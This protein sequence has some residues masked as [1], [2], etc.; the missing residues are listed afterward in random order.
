MIYAAI[1]G[2]AALCAAAESGKS[3]PRSFFALGAVGERGGHSSIRATDGILTLMHAIKAETT[4]DEATATAIP[5][6]RPLLGKHVEIIALQTDGGLTET[7][8]RKFTPAEFF[9]AR[10][11]PP[12]GVGPI[13]LEDMESAIEKG[14]VGAID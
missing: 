14:A 4:V 2:S 6:L 10:L 12:S 1:R 8:T 13:S 11:T 5:A 7:P 3:A 9:A